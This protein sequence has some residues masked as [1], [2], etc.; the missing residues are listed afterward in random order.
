MNGETFSHITYG[1]AG[2]TVFLGATVQQWGIIGIVVG[3]GIGLANLAV[4]TW[5]RRQLVKIAKKK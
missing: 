3:I 4:N 1:A 5:C 2:T